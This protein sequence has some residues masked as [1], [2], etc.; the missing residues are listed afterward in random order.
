MI[1]G[2]GLWLLKVWWLLGMLEVAIV[3][4]ATETIVVVN[5]RP[6]TK[7]EIA[8]AYAYAEKRFRRMEGK[9]PASADDKRAVRR[10]Q[11][12]MEG[13][14]LERRIRGVIR[15]QVSKNLG[16]SVTNEEVRARWRELTE[17]VDIE[18]A[19]VEEKRNFSVLLDALEEVYLAGENPEHVYDSLLMERMSSR[20]WEVHLAYYESA[21]KRCAF[22]EFVN[23]P[24]KDQEDPDPAIRGM[25]LAEQLDAAVDAALERDDAE[26]AEYLRLV[27][28]DPASSKVQS[29]GPMYRA[30]KRY[31]WWHERYR[32]AKIEMKDDRFKEV[33]KGLQQ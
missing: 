2:Q 18:R 23:E 33:V 11:H 30:A 13:E 14:K 31:E 4:S 17:N 9:E 7:S 21:E 28:T 3:G 12:T 16:V 5:G 19:Q 27:K 29:K 20:E 15:D 32:Q 10:L 6:I 8:V 26:F 22:R 24:I 1:A 25:M